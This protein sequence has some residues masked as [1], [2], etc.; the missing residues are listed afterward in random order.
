MENYE[1]YHHGVK[2]MK[3]G[4]RKDRVKS[5][6]SRIIKRLKT[7]A[8]EFSAKRKARRAREESLEEERRLTTTSVK[9]L[10]SEELQK[11][12]AILQQR[13]QA[14]DIEKQCNQINS[15]I[16]DKG[17][18]FVNKMVK[19]ALIPAAVESG[20]SVL[21]DYFIKIG[22]DKLGLSDST[23]DGLPPVKTW[24]DITKRQT[25]EANLRRE[26]EEAE[27]RQQQQQQQNSDGNS[28]RN[29][30]S[31]SDSNSNRNQNS[32]GNANNDSNSNRNQNSNSDSNNNRNQ[33]S[34]SDS[35]SNRTQNSNSDSRSNGPE[36]YN[37]SPDDILGNGNS[38]RDTSRRTGPVVDADWHPV[39]D[40][41]TTE[42]V[43][44]GNTTR[45]SSSNS[46]SNRTSNT[47]SSTPT[48]SETV[49]RAVRNNEIMQQRIREG[50]A[51]LD[52]V[53]A[54]LNRS[55]GNNR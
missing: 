7:S 23:G 18:S 43:R 40:N 1:L 46:N 32:N 28:N 9:K 2:G 4:V 21:K 12:A 25:Y 29:Q 16:A 35:N 51:R 17:K 41:P 8:S 3:W 42:I 45:T 54:R 24:D 50:Q 52:E 5:A 48:T 6:G 31:N 10:T 14:L 39:N 33:N 34:N 22:K 47:R 44:V 30:N 13:K 19:D 37:P 55:A 49:D 27:R 15:E 11:R 26:R 36:R 20:K 38:R 53:L